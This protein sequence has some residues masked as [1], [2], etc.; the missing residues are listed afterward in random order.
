MFFPL[1]KLDAMDIGGLL[2]W[3][4]IISYP[5][6]VWKSNVEADALSRI[7]WKKCDETIQVD[8][9]LAIVVAAIAG[10]LVNIE[11]ISCSVQPIEA[12]FPVWSETST[13]K[14]ITRSFNQS[15]NTSGTWILWAGEHIKCGWL[16]TSS[17][18]NQTVRKEIESKCMTIQDWV[19]AQ[20]KDKK[21]NEIVHLFKSKRLHCHKIS[22]SDNN[23][24]KQCI[25]QCNWLFMRK[26]VLYHKTEMSCPDRSTM[27]LVLPEAFRKQALQ[28]CHDHLGHLRKEQM[29]DLLL[30]H[31]Y[32][33]R[34]LADMIKH[35]K[36]CKRCLKCKALLE[37]APMEKIDAMYPMELVHMDYLT[38]EANEGGWQRCSHLSDYRSLYVIC[39]GY[40]H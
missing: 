26:G 31:F 6:Q 30:D 15:Y 22:T 16:W 35:I 36:Q 34:M 24:I 2:A 9:I 37:K 4:T 1:P 3:L 19:E 8:S 7:D 17:T 29:I 33:P 39:I 5:L 14:V 20:S 25:R 13:N 38:I 28:G 10:D 18:S 40:S 11:S 23:E 32:W 12:F 21:I 27:Q